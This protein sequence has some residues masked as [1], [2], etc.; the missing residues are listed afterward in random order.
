M[1]KS[2]KSKTPKVS[3]PADDDSFAPSI[4]VKKSPPNS[5]K[6]KRNARAPF[7]EPPVSSETPQ[8]PPIFTDEE[9]AAYRKRMWDNYYRPPTETEKVECLAAEWDDTSVWEERLWI[10]EMHLEKHMKKAAWSADTT[11]AVDLLDEQIQE[12]IYHLDRLW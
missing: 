2:N 4:L 7:Q 1:P 8:A 10:L 6:A 12:C 3:R 9:M 11:L 5:R